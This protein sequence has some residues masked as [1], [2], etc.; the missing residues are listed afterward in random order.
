[1]SDNCSY[2]TDNVATVN[3]TCSVIN[4]PVQLSFTT[5]EEEV[6]MLQRKNKI[7]G[8]IKHLMHQTNQGSQFVDLSV[9][10]ALSDKCFIIEVGSYLKT[11]QELVTDLITECNRTLEEM[12]S[13]LTTDNDIQS[14]ELVTCRD[15]STKNKFKKDTCHFTKKWYQ[16]Y[17]LIEYSPVT[18]SAYC[19][20]CRLFGGGPGNGQEEDA[21]TTTGVKQWDKMKGSRGKNKSGKLETHFKSDSHFLSL[22][23]YLNFK[24]RR[25]NI[26]YILDANIQQREQLKIQIA[27][28]NRAAVKVL[29][30]CARYLSRQDLAFRGHTDEDGNYFQLVNLL[31]KYN[32]FIQHWLSD[33]QNRS[34][35]VTYMSKD[36]QNEFIQLI[37]EIMLD[38]ILKEIKSA[39]YYSLMADST[40]DSNRQD[41]FS[42]FIRYVDENLIPKERLIS[43]KET[44]AKTGKLPYEKS[45]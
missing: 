13:Y 3:S 6:G 7:C 35:K 19:F 14:S 31:A 2:I 9:D 45:Y 10:P 42:I 4:E 28:S 17:P 27:K 11:I 22:K 30:D 12:P 39:R 20:C 8:A 16:E 37:G 18:N 41:M 43:I 1:M 33:A 38:K 29:I 5:I 24:N 44:I 15:P 26:D 23:R 25:N 34:Y 40:P 21:W 32:P 36:S